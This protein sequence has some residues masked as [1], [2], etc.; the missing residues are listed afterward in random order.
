MLGAEKGGEAVHAL[1]A[2][3]DRLEAAAQ[4]VLGAAAIY[5]G[6]DTSI[7]GS[8]VML[9][10]FFLSSLFALVLVVYMCQGCTYG[11]VVTSKH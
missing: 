11:R 5:D 1:A 9:V 10:F 2:D 7:S 8:Q 4:L 3:E 6:S